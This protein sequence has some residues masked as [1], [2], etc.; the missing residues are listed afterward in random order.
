MK[1]H[2]L[3]LS[4]VSAF[5]P[6]FY[7]E[8]AQRVS[9]VPAPSVRSATPSN[10]TVARA[11]LGSHINTRNIATG[12]IGTPIRVGNLTPS[13]STPNSGLE[14]RVTELEDDVNEL[15]ADVSTLKGDVEFLRSLEDLGSGVDSAKIELL[16]NTAVNEKMGDVE[17]RMDGADT[18]ITTIEGL[19][20]ELKDAAEAAALNLD[21]QTSSSHIQYSVDGKKTW[22]NLIELSK[23]GLT[24][25]SN[26]GIYVMKVNNGIA[27]W[28]EREIE[29]VW[30]E[31]P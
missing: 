17:T 5:L 30:T 27:E 7:A 14:G 6:S 10:A 25:P 13:T 18:K 16:I 24:P 31:R 26:P 29:N 23:L 2:L 28:E 22:E 15:K 1:K 20:A 9:V 12:G 21:F 8:A 19:V 3:F 11:S 4:T